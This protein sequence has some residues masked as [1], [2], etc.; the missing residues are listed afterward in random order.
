MHS[1]LQF[2]STQKFFYGDCIGYKI[3]L[4][5]ADYYAIAYNFYNS[6]NKSI[7]AGLIRLEKNMRR[8]IIIMQPTSSLFFLAQ[9]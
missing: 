7:L 4:I 9:I 5:R 6:V 3:A 1:L 2:C 8:L